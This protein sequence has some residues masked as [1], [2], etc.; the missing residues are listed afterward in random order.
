MEKNPL[1]LPEMVEYWTGAPHSGYNNH[2]YNEISTIV[3]GTLV[4]IARG[5]VRVT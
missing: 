4:T 1:R 3:H 5:H 2:T